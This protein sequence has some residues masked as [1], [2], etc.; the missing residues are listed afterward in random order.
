MP[1]LSV[2]FGLIIGGSLLLGAIVGWLFRSLR[3][4]RQKMAISAEWSEELNALRN[5]EKR[6]NNA[7]KE[8][9]AELAKAR[10]ELSKYQ[11]TRPERLLDLSAVDEDDGAERTEDDAK[12]DDAQ[13]QTSELPEA[14]VAAESSADDEAV[15]TDLDELK[16]QL[17]DSYAKRDSLRQQLS[18]IIAK[19]REFTEAA[20]QK[21]EKIFALSRELETWQQRVPPLVE[22]YKDLGH[23]NTAVLAELEAEKER[24]E[25]LTN[26]LQTRIMPSSNW[27]EY[28]KAARASNSAIAS[29]DED[30]RDDLKLIR[31]VGPVLEKT[32]NKLGIFRFA[33]IAAFNQ[34]DIERISENLPQ[35]PGRIQ[36]DGW[37]EQARKLLQ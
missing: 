13:P 5:S 32:L 24:A 11:Q 26:T 3:A 30:G 10:H 1:E 6:T 20:K 35:F 16:A 36:R 37:I 23:Q 34:T 14:Q 22:R 28:D 25:K 8:L 19:T 7:R 27:H 17:A 2:A 18:A 4:E 31:G 33:Q 21:D 15:N 9:S 12:D 29:A